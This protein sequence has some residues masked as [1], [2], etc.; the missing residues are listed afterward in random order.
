MH[1]HTIAQAMDR[2]NAGVWMSPLTA[3][4]NGLFCNKSVIQTVPCTGHKNELGRK[5]ETRF[6]SL[7]KESISSITTS[8]APF[9]KKTYKPNF[10]KSVKCLLQE[11][12]SA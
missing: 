9:V 2:D 12:I 4:I 1:V 10:S 7:G 5:Q 11:E 8:K 6:V 3:S